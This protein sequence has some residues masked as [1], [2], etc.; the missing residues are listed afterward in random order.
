MST[1]K[2]QDMTCG[3]CEK[4]IKKTLSEAHPEAQIKIELEKKLLT[5]ENLSDERVV[6]LLN[7]SGYNPEKIKQ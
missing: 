2:V 6:F 5:V 7:E 1:F 4:T 3:H